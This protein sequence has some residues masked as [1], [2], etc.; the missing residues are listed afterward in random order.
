MGGHLSWISGAPPC[1]NY[2]NHWNI[3]VFYTIIKKRQV[4]YAFSDDVISDEDFALLYDVNRSKN[5]DFEYWLHDSF[6]LNE[7]S[8]DD[9]VAEFRFQKNDITRLANAL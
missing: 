6:D 7:I 2:K 4:L 8:D 3:N 5:R 9:C 1:R